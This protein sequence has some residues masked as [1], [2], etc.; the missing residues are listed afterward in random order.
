MIAIRFRLDWQG[1]PW[2]PAV[3]F[4]WIGQADRFELRHVQQK[5]ERLQIEC[6]RL[7]AEPFNAAQEFRDVSARFLFVG[8]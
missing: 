6:S 5:R 7:G 2:S 3:A 1:F 4:S 8:H